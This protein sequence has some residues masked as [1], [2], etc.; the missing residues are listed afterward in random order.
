MKKSAKYIEVSD[1]AP[2]DHIN[3]YN[4]IKG[5]LVTPLVES[6]YSTEN[7]AVINAPDTASFA[8]HEITALLKTYQYVAWVGARAAFFHGYSSSRYAIFRELNQQLNL[9]IKAIYNP[10]NNPPDFEQE[11]TLFDAI[12]QLLIEHLRK[13]KCSKLYNTKL[14]EVISILESNIKSNV[15][16]EN[17]GYITKVPKNVVASIQ[18]NFKALK[19]EN[20]QLKAALVSANQ[21]IIDV[22]ESL[23]ARLDA[24]EKQAESKN[25]SSS[26]RPGFN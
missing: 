16:I 13:M 21:A 15:V 11:P 24:L 5:L 25:D 2:E 4:L 8:H 20:T 10:E 14:L 19:E 26:K 12:N 17:N 9:A 6:D 22:K 18:S 1:A 23:G 3:Y 7:L